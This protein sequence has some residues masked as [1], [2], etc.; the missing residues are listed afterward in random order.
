MY[1]VVIYNICVL[2]LYLAAQPVSSRQDARG[3]EMHEGD[4]SA[5]VETGLRQA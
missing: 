3:A 1:T 5:R 4:M 2:L